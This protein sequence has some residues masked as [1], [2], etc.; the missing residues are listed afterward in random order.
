MDSLA[1]D[2]LAYEGPLFQDKFGRL[3]VE[4]G[5]GFKALVAQADGTIAPLMLE[6]PK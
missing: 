5:D 2:L 3:C 4:A 6:G 1:L